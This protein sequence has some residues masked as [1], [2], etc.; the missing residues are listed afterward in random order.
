MNRRKGLKLRKRKLKE[1]KKRE[2]EMAKRK[3]EERAK[4][5]AERSTRVTKRAALHL[6]RKVD[7]DSCPSSSEPGD[8]VLQRNKCK[9]TSSAAK[10]D[11]ID[12][13]QCC[14][15]FRTFEDDEVGRM[16]V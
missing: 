7:K 10:N 2:K 14:V 8:S 13:N 6:K 5:A 12:P 1:R 9:T 3:A 11:N 16:C 15:C 4:K